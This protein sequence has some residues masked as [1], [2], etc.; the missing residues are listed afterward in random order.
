MKTFT[1]FL[2]LFLLVTGC[3]SPG[4]P[5]NKAGG[6]N[7]LAANSDSSFISVV[8]PIIPAGIITVGGRAADVTGC[9]SEAIQL[10]IDALHN[11]GG[12]TVKL[13]P[14]GFIITAPVKLYSNISLEGSGKETV[15]KK[16]RGFH[17]SFAVD[18]DYG[19]LQVTVTDA[20]GFSPGMG[21]AIYDDDQRSG[22]ALTTA[23]IVSIK[24]NT[25]Y[26]DDYLLRDYRAD[27]NG[28]ISN[29]CSVI[30]AVEADNVRISN[31]TVDGS[32]ETNE[33]IDGCRAGGVYLHKVSNAVV[34]NVIVKNF[35]S[36]GISWQ[37]TEHV[38]VRK[39]MVSGCANSGLHPGTGSPYSIIEE[40]ISHD[41][42]GYGLFV[43]WRVRNGVVRDNI[44]NNN[45]RNGICTGHKDTDMLFAGNH[46][47]DNGSDG[48]NLR[49][50]SELNAPHRSIF[51]DNII[52][53]NGT[54]EEGYG[55]SINCSAEGVV[56]E[57]NIIRNS[58]NGKQIAAVMLRKGSRD[59]KM[60][61]NNISGHPKGD[62]VKE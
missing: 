37:I 5:E 62:V 7:L 36:D 21:V 55:L 30:E 8:H 46:I 49:G 31:L 23:R 28:T 43:C 14:A 48:V 57:N 54:K 42:G 50:E 11:K 51:R 45:G 26:L 61:G 33:M 16:C 52:E 25:I 47:F 44:F 34:E 32:L 40:N 41:N 35:N 56:L 3:V 10:A 12:G 2:M 13:L 9:T 22:W 18:A 58:G 38:T 1:T 39:C 17:S 4:N 24:D 29:A 60:A 15:L 53:N 59:V 27:K 20:S 6:I 19:E